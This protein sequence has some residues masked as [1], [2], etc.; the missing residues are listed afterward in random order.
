MTRGDGP[1]IR[2]RSLV[3]VQLGPHCDG[4]LIE[5]R[6]LATLEIVL[7]FLTLASVKRIATGSGQRR[8]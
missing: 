6:G 8:N 5:G 2:M 4:N 3:Q 7:G 1:L